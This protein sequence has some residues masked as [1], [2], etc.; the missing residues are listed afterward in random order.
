VEQAGVP[1]DDCPTQHLG[2]DAWHAAESAAKRP[3]KLAT[4]PWWRR[5]SLALLGCLLL[6]CASVTVFALIVAV[7]VATRRVHGPALVAVGAVVAL[8]FFSSLV[9]G[10]RDSANQRAYDLEQRMRGLVQ[11]E[12][13][14]V[15]HGQ[16]AIRYEVGLLRTEL[17]ALL[18]PLPA[19]VIRYGDEREDA[20]E[21]RAV[22]RLTAANETEPGRARGTASVV[23]LRSVDGGGS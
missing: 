10:Q 22:R 8:A 6:T 7:D 21:T 19:G 17:H 20:G 5:I 3:G 13:Y 23:R 4:K 14:R 18:G 9:A 2:L 12:T 16:Q 1:L 15:E 11:F